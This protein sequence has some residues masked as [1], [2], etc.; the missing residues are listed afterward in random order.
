M[1]LGKS[2]IICIEHKKLLKK[3]GSY[4]KSVIQDYFDYILKRTERKY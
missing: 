4:S 2:Y 1:K 3:Y